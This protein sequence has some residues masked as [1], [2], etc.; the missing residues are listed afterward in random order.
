MVLGDLL[1]SHERAH[2]DA[3]VRAIKLL[4]ICSEITGSTDTRPT[5]LL[6]GNHDRRNNSDFQS[7][8]H[9]FTGL[10]LPGVTIIDKATIVNIPVAGLR[11]GQTL[12]VMAPFVF[13]P[14]VPPGRLV[15]ALDTT[16]WRTT[17]P[18]AIFCHQEF[19][20]VQLGAIKSVH[21]DE[22]LL[23][24]PLVISGHIHEYQELQQN[25]L[26]PGT[27]IQQTFA[28][29]PDKSVLVCEFNIFDRDAIERPMLKVNKLTDMCPPVT[30]GLRYCRVG[31]SLPQKK[32]VTTTVADLDNVSID[33]T[34]KTKLIVSGTPS[35]LKALTKS[36]KLEA[37]SKA[38]VKVNLVPLLEKKTRLAPVD[39][40]GQV[41][42]GFVEVLR[43]LV[44]NDQE[45]AT[46]VDVL[47]RGV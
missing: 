6:I 36:R 37:Y 7:T 43:G 38:G 45:L 18:L 4:K 9:F 40:S 2:L 3:H 41:A 30:E 42:K 13:A 23:N 31:L 46:A 21:G 11:D 29:S 17:P 15:E 8:D 5:W 34:H 25:I 12:E 20:G 44:A 35:E 32:V 10:S 1:D 19:R 47:I 39:Q 24:Y 16:E 28:E 33:L 27:P 22:W 26:Y 14:Y